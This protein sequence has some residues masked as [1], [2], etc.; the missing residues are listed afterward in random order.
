M[1][2][3]TRRRVDADGWREILAR[4]EQSGLSARAFCERE[5]INAGSLY[6]W[7]SRLGQTSA[8]EQKVQSGPVR[9]S[10]SRGFIELGALGSSGSRFEVR[11]DLGGGLS[12][13]LVR[14]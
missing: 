14:S 13:H 6:R 4:Q 11:L 2:R 3:T 5:G 10:A 1:E 8:P 7:R 9:T 12:L